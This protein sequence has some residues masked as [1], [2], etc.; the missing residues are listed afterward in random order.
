MGKDE[1]DLIISEWIGLTFHMCRAD[2]HADASYHA[3]GPF[4]EDNAHRLLQE[5]DEA[6]SLYSNMIRDLGRMDFHL[7]AMQDAPTI[8]ENG[9]N[10][11]R[12]SLVDR[13]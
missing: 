8:S 2:P 7:N 10:A 6:R 9:A 11:S 1:Y 3:T 5:R 13:R 12:A 4:T